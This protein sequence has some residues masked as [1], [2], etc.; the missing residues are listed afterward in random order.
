M[1]A[2][3]IGG[4]AIWAAL[5]IITVACTSACGKEKMNTFKEPV[6]TY[7][8]GRFVLDIPACM[9]FS[10]RYSVRTFDLKE[11]VWPVEDKQK[12]AQTTWEKILTEIDQKKPPK[13]QNKVMIEAREFSSTHKWCKS[14]FFYGDSYDGDRGDLSILLNSDMVGLWITTYG[15]FTGKDF[16]Y[17]K[18]SD[19]VHAYR[20]PT[21]RFGRVQVLSG[22]DSFY[23]QYGAIDLPFEYS[24]S[25]SV[26][27]AGHPLDE[28]ML[29][30][31]M[32]R[33]VEEDQ[34]IGL[35]DR[36]AS[37]LTLKMAKGLKI[38]KLR[39]GKRTVGG[40]KGEEILER[41]TDDGRVTLAFS[42]MH[43]GKK[44]SAHQPHIII[45]ME[46]QDGRPEEKLAL[47]DAVLDSMRPAGRGE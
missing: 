21:S 12:V 18:A 24:E 8:A 13:G 33:V 26:D 42:W 37:S 3:T 31:V 32:T 34:K 23:L 9:K 22:R 38:D 30:S 35:L 15:E 11:D 1:N 45:D 7:G 2:I 25:V 19:L 20:P 41:F 14:V 47:W 16:M 27:F 40:L 17:D 6:I 39:S 10:G 36:A 29:I 44:D 43:L 28:K 46:S 5:I 4:M